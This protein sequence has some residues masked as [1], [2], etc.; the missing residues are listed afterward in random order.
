MTEPGRPRKGTARRSA[1]ALIF[2]LAAVAAAIRFF[3]P[4]RYAIY[5]ACPFRVLT[6]LKCPGCG[7][8]HAMTALLAGRWAEAWH[9][10]P[11]A[12]V[13]APL[14]AGLLAPELYR[15]LRYDR[16]RPLSLPPLATGTILAAM[17]VFGVIRNLA[18]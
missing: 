13:L 14:I 1:C 3:P 15:A 10:N 9:A 8:T 6:G 2:G 16:W 5:P 17:A 7:S 18:G 11:L 4:D 12:I